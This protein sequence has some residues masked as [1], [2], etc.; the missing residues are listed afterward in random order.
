MSEGETGGTV[1]STCRGCQL[2]HATLF[3]ENKVASAPVPIDAKHVAGSD[4]TG[5]QQIGQSANDVPLHCSLQ[6]TRTV[7]PICAFGKEELLACCPDTKLKLHLSRLEHAHL[8]LTQLELENRKQLFVAQGIEDDDF[9]QPIH[10]FGR[11][12]PSRRLRCSSSHFLFQIRSKLVGS[13]DEPKSSGHQI[14]D[15]G[16]AKIRSE[17]DECSRKIDALIIS[18][19]Q[20]GLIQNPQQQL[21]EGV[22]RLLDFVEEQQTELQLVS[23]TL[24]QRLLGQERMRLAVAQV[25]WRRAD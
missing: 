9:V 15:A 24:F 7:A 14:R 8:D 13:V 5:C 20:C 17:K 2:R 6:M 23:V 11:E 19:G 22:T 4:L 21:P 1:P 3:P 16:S 18:Q 10:E 25:P 12:G